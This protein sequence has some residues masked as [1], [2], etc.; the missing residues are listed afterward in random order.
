QAGPAWGCQDSCRA[1]NDPSRGYPLLPDLGPAF[2]A[3]SSAPGSGNLRGG[4][5]NRDSSHAAARRS[6]RDD[7]GAAY[8]RARSANNLMQARLIDVEEIA[9]DVRHF[10]F[11]A[12]GVARLDFLPGQFV[13]LSGPVEGRTI[14]RA[15]SIASAPRDGNRFELCLNRVSDG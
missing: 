8:A 14:T 2:A 9:P 13:S 7:R 3:R 4:A 10:V 6:P 15:Y 5:G 1:W 11:E 12:P